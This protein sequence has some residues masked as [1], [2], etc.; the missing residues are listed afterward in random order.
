VTRATALTVAGL[1]AMGAVT[2][3]SD[4]GTDEPPTL[5]RIDG[6]AQVDP[7]YEPFATDRAAP[8]VTEADG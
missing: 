4:S 7:S 8:S 3:C 6:P 2:G 5:D 1:V